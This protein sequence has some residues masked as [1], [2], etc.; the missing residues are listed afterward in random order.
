MKPDK[1]IERYDSKNRLIE[2]S[3]TTYKTIYIYFY[4]SEDIYYVLDIPSDDRYI[5]C[6][7]VCERNKDFYP[8]EIK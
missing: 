4:D 8:D 1:H 6:E 3:D 2:Y 5:A 7:Y